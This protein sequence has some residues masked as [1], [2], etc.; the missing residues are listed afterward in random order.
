MSEQNSGGTRPGANPD[1]PGSDIGAGGSTP[2]PPAPP[3]G[4]VGWAPGAELPG[5]DEVAGENTPRLGPQAH[6]YGDRGSGATSNPA[7]PRSPQDRAER[8]SA[9]PAPSDEIAQY[10]VRRSRGPVIAIVGL[11]I[12]ILVTMAAF[13]LRRPARNQD[14]QSA[15]PTPSSATNSPGSSVSVVGAIPVETESFSG[16]WQINSADWDATG[17]TIDMTITSTSG[18]LSFTMFTIDNVN[19]GQVEG[20]GEMASG[21]V[22]DGQTMQGTVHFDKDRNDTTIVLANAGGRQIT[23]LTVPA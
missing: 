3:P 22:D 2:P 18:S 14:E 4:Q 6:P 20:T 15:P 11:V 9:R 19:T 12:V 10:A 16:S 5:F 8:P 13:A 1:S 17:L 23:A 7:P 21:T